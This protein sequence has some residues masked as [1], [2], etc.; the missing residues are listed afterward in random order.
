MQEVA[1]K[2]KKTTKTRKRQSR[3]LRLSLFLWKLIKIP[4][5]SFSIAVFIF[6]TWFYYSGHYDFVRQKAIDANGYVS[7]KS[8]LVLKD[9]LL[10]GQEYTPKEDIIDIMT[11]ATIDDSEHLTIGDPILNIDLKRIR[12]KLE[13]LT[14]VKHASVERL[15]PSTLSVS[16]IERQPIALWQHDGI[17][18]LIDSDGKV[19]NTQELEKFSDLIILV[20]DESPSHIQSLFNLL[21]SQPDLAKRVSSVIR[22]G[23]R[24]WNVRFMNDVEVKLPEE[25]ASKAWAH[26]AQLQQDTSIL[27]TDISNIDLRIKDENK[28]F[29]K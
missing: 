20:G 21:N 27:D 13:N 2:K 9:I 8:G 1:K 23:K 22:V 19:I 11:K 18:Q 10:E 7:V 16:I 14:W 12:R 15:Y 26:L 6:C 25:N 29:V 24:R 4:Q 17:V 28:I 3:L 5:L